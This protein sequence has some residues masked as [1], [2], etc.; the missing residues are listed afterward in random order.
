MNR[1][2]LSSPLLLFYIYSGKLPP[3]HLRTSLSYS[4]ITVNEL[5]IISWICARFFCHTGHFQIHTKFIYL[6]CN[7]LK[8]FFVHFRSKHCESRYCPTQKTVTTPVEASEAF[9]SSYPYLSS[10]LSWCGGSQDT[11]CLQNELVHKAYII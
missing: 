2:Y 1:Y 9:I 4:C 3:S 8:I 6:V 5:I 10:S 7:I 11:S